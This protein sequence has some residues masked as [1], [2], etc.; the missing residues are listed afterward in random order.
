MLKALAETHGRKSTRRKFFG[1][2]R[3]REERRAARYR[4]KRLR[5]E[6]ARGFAEPEDNR[7]PD[8]EVIRRYRRPS[9]PPE[10]VSLPVNKELVIFSVRKVASRVHKKLEVVEEVASCSKR[11]NDASVGLFGH[12]TSGSSWRLW[13]DASGMIFSTSPLR[14]F[15]DYIW[16]TKSCGRRCRAYK[17]KFACALLLRIQREVFFHKDRGAHRAQAGGCS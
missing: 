1:V 8:A 16:R 5:E 7:D 14:P 6:M 2:G 17:P 3:L 9:S 13:M 11:L 10:M 15:L 4:A 12:I